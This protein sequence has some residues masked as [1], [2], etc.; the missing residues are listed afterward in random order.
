MSSM[1]REI[2]A[3][4][5]IRGWQRQMEY[6][7]KNRGVLVRKEGEESLGEAIRRKRNQPYFLVLRESVHEEKTSI[8]LKCL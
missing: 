6:I 1:T 8:I 4:S 7:L 3:V 2:V 5:N